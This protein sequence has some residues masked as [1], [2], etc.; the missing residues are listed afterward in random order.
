MACLASSYP[1]ESPSAR[2]VAGRP[3]F[4]PVE[5]V[6][7]TVVELLRKVSNTPTV[8]LM[9]DLKMSQ[10]ASP[11]LALETYI[12]CCLC[13]GTEKVDQ[14]IYFQLTLDFNLY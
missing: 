13:S 4:F 12:P 10:S 8:D 14:M 3:S 7:V 5:N 2:D 11:E 1:L 9:D 6:D